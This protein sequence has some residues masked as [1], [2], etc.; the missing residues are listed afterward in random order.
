[1]LRRYSCAGF[2]ALLSPMLHSYHFL[3]KGP[4]FSF[5]TRLVLNMSLHIWQPKADG[6]HWGNRVALRF[7]E[8]LT[9]DFG[10]EGKLQSG[11]RAQM[12]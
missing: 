3:I 10:L 4:T 2:G 6:G 7:P 11:K 1:M 8:P 5:C 9:F 12:R